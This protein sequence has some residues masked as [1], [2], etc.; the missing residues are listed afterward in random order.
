MV[1]Y[2]FKLVIFDLDDTLYS[3][4]LMQQRVKNK[5]NDIISSFDIDIEIFWQNYNL[6]EAKLFSDFIHSKITGKDYM[7]KRYEDTLKVVSSKNVVLA[8]NLNSIYLDE[9]SQHINLFED[10][11]PTLDL[12]DEINVE[13][14]ILTNGPLKSQKVKIQS[15]G[16]HNFIKKFYIS[17]EIKV[18]K[19][20]KQAFKFVLQDLRIDETSTVMVGDSLKY[21]ILSCEGTGITPIL[22]D[23]FDLNRDI[24]ETKFKF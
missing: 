17:E 2:I 19:P 21:D 22:I 11:K 23:R 14:V 13:K 6:I 20:D 3:R 9:I 18:S 8:T 15:L 5:I 10:V 16:L 7:L 24:Q 4:K 12:L 1:C